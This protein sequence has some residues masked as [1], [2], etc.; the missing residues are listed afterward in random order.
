MLVG[1][2]E[3]GLAVFEN[4]LVF[5]KVKHKPGKLNMSLQGKHRNEI[6]LNPTQPQG[7]EVTL[8]ATHLLTAGVTRGVAV[9]TSD[10]TQSYTA[11]G[12]STWAPSSPQQVLPKTEEDLERPQTSL[13]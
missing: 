13:C 7:P 2:K 4:S 10:D 12:C 8:A 9:I 3:N 5:E 1:G 6:C 11:C